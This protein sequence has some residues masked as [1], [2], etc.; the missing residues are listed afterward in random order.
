MHQLLTE[1]EGYKK[2]KALDPSMDDYEI[3]KNKRSNIDHFNMGI[4]LASIYLAL[5]ILDLDWLKM[6]PMLIFYLGV[7][8]VVNYY[9]FK[10]IFADFFI[11]SLII[12]PVISSISYFKIMSSKWNFLQSKKI[13]SLLKE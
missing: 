11:L 6:G 4:N 5:I 2:M 7:H 1:Y 13:K 3:Q 8:H 10:D 9:N 12:Q